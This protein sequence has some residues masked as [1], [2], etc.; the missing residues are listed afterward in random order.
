MTQF[1]IVSGIYADTAPDLRTGY[2]VNL[3][4]V[5]KESGVSQGYLRPGDGLVPYT[6]GP[7]LD[8][9]GIMW[10]GLHYR[11]M[12]D[13]LVSVAEDGIVIEIG[14]VGNDGKPVTLTYSF[15]YLAI[16]SNQNL[17]LYNGT[18]Q[19]VTDPD[20]GIVLDV[21]WIDGF[22]M[23]TEGINLVVTELNNP[24]A[25]NPL[26]YGASEID[27][28]AVVALKKIRNEAVA[29]NRH[30]IEYF[31]NI[32]TELFPFARING[33]Q[34]QKG[35]VGTHACC[36]FVE[37]LA[38]LG[39]GFNEQCSVYIGQNA[40]ATKIATHEIDTI[41]QNYTEAELAEAVLE[42]RGDKA[43]RLLYVHLP[44][45]TLVYDAAASLDMKQAVW[46]VLTSAAAGYERYRAR[47][48][49]WAYNRWIFGDT[50]TN[51]LGTVDYAVSTHFGVQ[52]RW[53]FSTPLVYNE[54]R[55]ALFHELEL[56]T[57]TGSQA[58]GEEPYISTSYSLDGVTWSN[59]AMI[60]SGVT[61]ERAKRLCWFRQGHMRNWRVQRFQGDSDSH[62]AVMRL[63][64]RL[65]PL[66][67]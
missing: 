7:G 30:T 32:G 65:E 57:L 9:G 50:D 28:D 8:R 60:R 10:N 23:T 45:R 19:Q 4:P 51:N 2:P 63:E 6:T 15:D 5:P 3:V 61:G 62:L 52:V 14:N 21:I 38:F 41:L 22:F 11:V 24:F 43:H 16:A 40:T 36:V 26:K 59:P 64:A 46:F 58:F 56:V 47:N 27:P 35:C 34:I 29:I 17:F 48:F 53:E 18:L 37:A 49:T 67:W 20:L 54:S 42:E 44:D 66:A 39:G 12:G 13:Q 33:A 31:D 1:P 55:G 25:V